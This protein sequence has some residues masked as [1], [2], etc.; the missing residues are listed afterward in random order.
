MTDTATRIVTDAVDA[1]R[2]LDDRIAI[3]RSDKLGLNQ[4]IAD[5]LKERKPL[6]RIVAAANPRQRKAQANGE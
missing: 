4:L 3:A 2:A 1:L 5:L 6:A